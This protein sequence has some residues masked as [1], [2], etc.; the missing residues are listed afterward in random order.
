MRRTVPFWV[1]VHTRRIAVGSTEVR[2]RK[3]IDKGEQQ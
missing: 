2:T 1:L 3:N